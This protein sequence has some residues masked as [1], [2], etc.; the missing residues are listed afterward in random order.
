M[1]FPSPLQTIIPS[2][3]YQEYADDENVVAFFTALNTIAQTYLDWFNGTS[4]AVYTS[5]SISGPLLDWVGNGI[6]GIARPVFS[7][8]MTIY[9]AGLNAMALNVAAL[10]GNEFFQSGT[11]TIATDD[12]YKRVLTWW[13]YAGNGGNREGVG[14]YFNNEVL[15]LKVARF[16]YGVNGTDVTLTQAQTV[17]I[18]PKALS[19]P[20]TPSVSYVAGGS[21]AAATYHAQT[22]YVNSLGETLAGGV[23][24]IAVPANSRLVVDSPAAENGAVS[25]NVY[26]Y[27]GSGPATKQNASPIPIGTNWTEPTSGLITGSAL[28]AANSSNSPGNF[29]ITV[30]AGQASIYFQQAMNQGL[31]AFPFVFTATVV[32][33]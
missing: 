8:E 18:Q 22:S 28:P 21:L 9:I 5:P 7:S 12:Y 3:P 30:P 13:L 25:Y 32:I 24:S 14:R 15:R 10:N 29:I 11:A 4:L 23:S 19:S 6:Y 26:A 17:Q 1:S 16:L 31:L 27:I 2:Y 33:A 20:P